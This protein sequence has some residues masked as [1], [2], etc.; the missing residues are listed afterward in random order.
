MNYI[1]LHH[2]GCSTSRNGLEFLE[3]NKVSP[4]LRLYMNPSEALTIEE[5]KSITKKLGAFSPRS[6][7]RDK[8]AAKIGITEASSDEE[9]YQAMVSHPLIIQRPIG[10][11]GNKAVVG[12]PIKRLLEIT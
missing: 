5:L 7:L 11:Y 4:Q 2:K 10:L 9:I 12:R 6:F 8:S 1:L 3:L